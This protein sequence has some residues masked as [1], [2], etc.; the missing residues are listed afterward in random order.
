MLT[1][2]SCYIGFKIDQQTANT[3]AINIIR[4]TTKSTKRFYTILL[5]KI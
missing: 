2:Y 5:F 1:K 3:I 4:N